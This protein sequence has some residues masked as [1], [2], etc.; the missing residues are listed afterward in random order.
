[1][2][3]AF[4]DVPVRSPYDLLTPQSGGDTYYASGDSN[5][6]LWD[7]IERHSDET[8]ATILGMSVASLITTF[9]LIVAIRHTERRVSALEDDELT[10]IRSILR[11]KSEDLGR[12]RA[13]SR[14]R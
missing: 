9:G 10:S 11:S 2:L 1:M 4:H 3:S 14:R 12:K 13:R 7:V 8:F 5:A 6:A